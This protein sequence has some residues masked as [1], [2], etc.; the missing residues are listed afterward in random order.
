MRSRATS[1]GPCRPNWM[2]WNQMPESR[3][4]YSRATRSVSPW[5]YVAEMKNISLLEALAE[6]FSGCCERLVTCSKS[7]IAAVEGYA[8]GAGCEMIEMCDIVVAGETARFG[9]P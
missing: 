2:P 1:S 7:L 3:S 4:S 9:H 6:D 5:A 8:I